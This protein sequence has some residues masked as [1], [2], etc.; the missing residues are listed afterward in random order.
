ML[1]SLD[2][3]YRVHSE[4]GMR[5]FIGRARVDRTRRRI[6]VAIDANSGDARTM[7]RGSQ[8]APQAARTLRDIRTGS[9]IIDLR[10]TKHK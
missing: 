3:E 4:T 9:R 5:R 1:V 10:R 2:C 7:R 8:P 6:S